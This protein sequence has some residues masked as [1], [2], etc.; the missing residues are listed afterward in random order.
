MVENSHGKEV[1]KKPL[2]GLPV[3]KQARPRFHLRDLTAL[4]AGR[5]Y[6]LFCAHPPAPN[7]AEKDLPKE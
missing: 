3:E 6:G 7:D 2:D 4:Y 1:E 5:A